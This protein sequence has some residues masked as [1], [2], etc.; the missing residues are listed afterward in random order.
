M[1]DGRNFFNETVK[2]NLR[3]YDT[4]QKI[5]TGQEKGYAT[6][7][8]WIIPFSIDL[9]KQQ[10]LNTDEKAIQQMFLLE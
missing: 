5:A 3:A 2:N 8:Y 9:S 4:I 10:A 7:F 6:G 1:S